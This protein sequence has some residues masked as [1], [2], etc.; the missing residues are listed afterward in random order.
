MS[1]V[2]G[3]SKTAQAGNV[4]RGYHT[5]EHFSLSSA[6]AQSPQAN[7]LEPLAIFK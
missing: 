1:G 2:S 4:A 7:T 3:V 5:G 6:A